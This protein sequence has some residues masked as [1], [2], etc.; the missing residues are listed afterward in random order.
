MEELSERRQ[1]VTRVEESKRSERDS[2]LHANAQVAALKAQLEKAVDAKVNKKMLKVSVLS[3]LIGMGKNGVDIPS[4][5]DA[6]SIRLWSATS[7]PG[8]CVIPCFALYS[9]R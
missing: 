8:Q 5:S 9:N 4:A 7:I 3:G 2:L 1:Q 6:N